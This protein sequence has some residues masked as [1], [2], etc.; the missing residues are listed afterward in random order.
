MS[1]EARTE[2]AFHRPCNNLNPYAETLLPKQIHLLCWERVEELN[3]LL[4][5]PSFDMCST[6]FSLHVL[7][8]REFMCLK[9]AE[10]A[11]SMYIIFP[12]NMPCIVKPHC[13]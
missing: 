2:I 13:V 10:D 9:T 11:L 1:G 7:S 12:S 3:K 5:Y 6:Y 4:L 8:C